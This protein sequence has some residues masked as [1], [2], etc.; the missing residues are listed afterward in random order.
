MPD[1]PYVFI[2]Y[3]SIDRERVLPLVDRLEQAGVKVWIDRVGIHGGANYAKVISDAVKDAS[4]LVLMTSPA[5]L[6]SRNVRQE[7]ALGW[8]YERS[9]L[10]LLLD[11]VEIPDD[12]A[13]WL[14]GSQWIEVLDR[15][16]HEWLAP[17][18]TA[19]EKVGVAATVAASAIHKPRPL[20]VGRE[21]EQGLLSEQLE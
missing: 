1:S 7:L 13:Y 4:V 19:L 21:R 20:L 3:A 10:P 17:T 6:A 11:L 12:L 14:E 15:P 9:Y 18:L 5:S 8:R 16:E 2:S